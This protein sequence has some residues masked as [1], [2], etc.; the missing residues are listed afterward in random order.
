MVTARGIV[1]ATIVVLAAAPVE[2]TAQAQQQ[3]TQPKRVVPNDPSINR[4][5]PAPPERT[6]VTPAPGPSAPMERIPPV[7]PPAQPPTR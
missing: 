3:N 1:A 4:P 6:Y 5:P 7:A 2:V